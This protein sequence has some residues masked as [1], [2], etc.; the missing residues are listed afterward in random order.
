MEKSFIKQPWFIIL[1]LGALI[2]AFILFNNDIGIAEDYAFTVDGENIPKSY[3]DS[4][5]NIYMEE[6][7]DIEEARKVTFEEIVNETILIQEANKEG[8]SFSKDS[9]EVEELYQEYVGHFGSEEELLTE[10]ENEGITEEDFKESLT[11][12]AAITHLFDVYTERE[13]ITE[14]DAL[15]MYAMYQSF[16]EEGEELPE[17]EEAKEDIMIYLAQ[18][19]ANNAIMELLEQRKNEIEISCTEEYAYFCE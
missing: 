19:N 2:S 12:R 17:F 5:L 3:V 10:M 9:K 18:E 1:F 16:S 14:E 13:E 11:K 7:E 8:I 15:E 6:T 4:S